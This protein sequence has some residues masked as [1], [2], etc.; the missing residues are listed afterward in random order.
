MEI[1]GVGRNVHIGTEAMQAI[2]AERVAQAQHRDVV[3]AVK[4]LNSTEMFGHDNQLTFQR[5]PRV[6]RMVVRIV[7]QQTQEV[8]AQ[9]PDE[10]VL[11]LAADFTK[12][13]QRNL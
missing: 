11:Q 9:I 7:N 5:D 4:A 2:P 12:A 10:S 8:V 1:S 13:E 6:Q 3:Q